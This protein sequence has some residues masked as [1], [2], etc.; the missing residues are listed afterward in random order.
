MA[1]YA[2]NTSVSVAK[3]RTEIESIL[4]RYGCDDFAYRNNNKIAQIAFVMEGHQIRFDLRL[5]D[6]D[7][8]EFTMTPTGRRRRDDVAALKAWEQAC[9]QRWRALVL[10]IKA[11]LEA[12]ESEITTLE[13]EFMSHMIVAGGKVFHEVALPQIAESYSTGRLPPLLGKGK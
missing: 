4:Q 3:S 2:S 11:K 8:S 10:I 6:Q 13:I 1:R 5:P 7:S 9:R 12:V